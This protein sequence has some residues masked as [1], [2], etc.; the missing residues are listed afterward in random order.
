[1]LEVSTPGRLD[2]ELVREAVLTGRFSLS[3]KPFLQ[4]VLIE[5]WDQLGSAFQHCLA[6]HQLSSHMWLAARKQ[7][8]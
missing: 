6:A 4:R 3:G 2:A 7:E 8:P 1:V 5:K